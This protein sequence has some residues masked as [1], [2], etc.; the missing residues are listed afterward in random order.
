MLEPIETDG[1]R[2]ITPDEEIL[3]LRGQQKQGK[4]I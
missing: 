2:S 4:R 1:I 3:R